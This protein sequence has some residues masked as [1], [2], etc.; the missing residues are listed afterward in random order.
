MT[1]RDP[2]D[3]MSK[4]ILIADDEPHVSKILAMKLRNAGY[5]VE[6]ARNGEEGLRLADRFSPDLVITDLQMPGLDGF[7]LALALR[8][9]QSTSD[10]PVIMLTAR[11][12]KLSPSDLSKTN[13]GTVFSKPFSANEILETVIRTIGPSGPTGVAA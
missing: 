8:E 6:S 4:R 2:G 3:A 10:T 9:A 12:H 5:A 13:I 1:H 11:G 7:S